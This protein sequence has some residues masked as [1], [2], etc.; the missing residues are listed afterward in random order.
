MKRQTSNDDEGLLNVN[1]SSISSTVEIPET[2][3]RSGKFLVAVEFP[4]NNDDWEENIEQVVYDDGEM[5]W[6]DVDEVYDTLFI[7]NVFQRAY[8]KMEEDVVYHIVCF[9]LGGNHDEDDMELVEKNWFDR[10][11]G[12]DLLDH[13]MNRFDRFSGDGGHINAYKS[14]HQST[15][16]S[17]IISIHE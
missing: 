9:T 11:K 8:E 13:V 2:Q 17:V 3:Q 10:Y 4:D 1:D 16:M 7:S 6:M 12:E 15:E 14:T 5:R